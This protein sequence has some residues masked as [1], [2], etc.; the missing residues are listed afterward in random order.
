LTFYLGGCGLFSGGSG[1]SL[2]ELPAPVKSAA[3][4]ITLDQLRSALKTPMAL[5][6]HAGDVLNTD[7]RGRSLAVV[8]RIYHLKDATAFLQA[9]Y[10]SFQQPG[11]GKA[12]PTFAAD[13]IQSREVVL[14][15]GQRHETVENLGPQVGAVGVV[16]LFRAPAEGRWRFAFDPRAS[17]DSG[18]TL[19]VHGCAL[20]VAQGAAIGVS[21]ELRRVAG[22][23]CDAAPAVAARDPFTVK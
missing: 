21:D 19:G 15:P 4:G 12:P 9:P 14:T 23:R 13:V 20:S 16:A 10:D 5:R 22:T 18:I 6:I 7:R 17:A 3:D 1:A 11:T 8:A 2:P